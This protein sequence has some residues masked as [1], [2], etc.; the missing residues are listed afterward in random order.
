MIEILEEK[1]KIEMVGENRL[2]GTINGRNAYP[3]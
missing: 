2:K 3:G 1:P